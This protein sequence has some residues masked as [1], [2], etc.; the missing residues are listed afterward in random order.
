MKASSLNLRKA[1]W[2]ISIF[3][4]LGLFVVSLIVG[5]RRRAL[6][7]RRIERSIFK[8]FDNRF[9]D[10]V[11]LS[12]QEAIARTPEF[13]LDAV[14]QKE[15]RQFLHAAIRQNIFT[16]YNINLFGIAFI[17]L[18]LD[19]PISTF[20]TLLVFAINVV[21]NV[22]QMMV[23]R[24]KLDAIIQSIRPH[25]T[26]I[27]DGRLHSVDLI[28]VVDG[29]C[30]VVR[31]GDAFLVSGELVGT[32][33]I[34]VNEK[35]HGDDFVERR[36]KPGDTVYAGSYCE[37]GYTV[38][39]SSECGVDRYRS[40][41][42]SE[43]QLLPKER[44][45]LQRLIE[46]LL[47]ALFGLVIVFS[48]IMIL[49]AVGK[50]AQIVSAEYRSAFSIIFGIAPMGL[51]IFILLKDIVGVLRISERG[52][53]VYNTRSL[54]TLA[55]VDTLCISEQGL[56]SGLQINLDPVPP[57]EGYDLL[58]EELIQSILGDIL[59]SVP[60]SSTTLRMLAESLPGDQHIPVEIAPF[61]R[62]YG[63]YG[64]SFED[65]AIK[66]TYVLGIQDVMED[67]LYEVLDA[68]EEDADVGQHPEKRGLGRVRSIFSR[69]DKNQLENIK[70][71]SKPDG[72]P[73]DEEAL[74]D[75]PEAE[76][77]D[78]KA[79]W[80]QKMMTNLVHWLTPVEDLD[81][82]NLE[83]S[84]PL[85]RT[86]LCFAYL[87]AVSPLHDNV[88]KPTLPRDLILLSRVEIAET[89]RVE[90]KDAIQKMIDADISIKIL[91]EA[92]IE[93]V[94]DTAT[95]L[96]LPIDET[97][98]ISG[99]DLRGL[100]GDEIAE[101][102]RKNIVFGDLTPAQKSEV[103]GAL[104]TSGKVVLMVG[105]DVSDV[106][107]LRQADQGVV[108]KSSSQAAIRHAD[109]VLLH[110][111]IDILPDIISI[112]V[113][114]VN[115][116]LNTFKLFLSQVVMQLILILLIFFN[117]L[118]AF[119]YSSVHAGVISVFTIAIPNIF[120]LFWASADRVSDKSIGQQLAGFILPAAAT[121]TLLIIGVGQFFFTRTAD[122][123]YMRMAVTYGILLAGW[124]RILFVQ[125]PTPF[126]VGGAPLRGDPRVIRLVLGCAGFLLA[127]LLVPFFRKQLEFSL[128]ASWLD[129]LLVIAAVF[130]W[131]IALRTLWRTGLGKSW[132]EALGEKIQNTT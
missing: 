53:L 131:V 28:Q 73:D 82:P 75:E 16:F 98:A 127:I 63:W 26:V 90:A 84:D 96:G 111:R 119:P 121:G 80:R 9:P 11:G 36:K 55:D 122:I 87:P 128:L 101:Q 1:V 132:V 35:S 50:Q 4:T 92:P 116:M 44:S 88:G 2:P 100:T 18:L 130:V 42:G 12:E 24:N 60:D 112:G 47:R 22:F 20:L 105:N 70:K 79:P 108:P 7:R 76:M 118:A 65:P 120:L 21:L 39:Q 27:R 14:Q 78:H 68:G 41:S 54:S 83:T 97:L 37:R 93:K 58:S 114:L 19:S 43:L 52:A 45:T 6:A 67:H 57:P 15:E 117:L 110:D 51:F 64:A 62:A 56:L 59:Q 129:Y 46:H 113:R 115:G 123:V 94:V 85:T 34:V 3:I 71:E 29:D 38:Y 13:D 72:D 125:P 124:L 91:G 23:T 99:S 89:V 33:E 102:A 104:Q 74:S 32:E 126:W 69:H 25:A 40:S 61:L 30:L 109:I 107:A 86:T 95:K 10:I 48:V 8:D 106:S 5:L 49:G 66:G 81:A 77:D 31:T 17:M 103:V